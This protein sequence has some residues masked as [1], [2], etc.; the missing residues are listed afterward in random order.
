MPLI[1]QALLTFKTADKKIPKLIVVCTHAKFSAIELCRVLQKSGIKVVFYPVGYS[2]EPENLDK[3]L[4]MGIQV[5][6]REEQLLP[7]IEK[8]DCG[9]ED[10]ARIS[11]VINKYHPILKK[12][13]FTVEQTSGGIR[14]F[15]EHPPAYPV[16][17]VAMSPVKLDIEN[18]RAT[19]EG[20]IQYFSETTGKTLGGKQVLVIG[21]GS[22]GEGLARFARILGANVTVYDQFAT[23]RMFAKHRGYAV[24]EQEEFDHILPRQDVIFMATNAYAGN[25]L[26]IEQ[27]LLMK[28]GAIVC[29]AGSGTGEVGPELHTAGNYS[30]H[31]AD[32]HIR[33]ENGHLV[34]RLKKGDLEK[35]VTILA[36]AFPINLHLGKGTSHDAIEVVMSLML[37]AALKGPEGT[38]AGLQPLGLDIQEHVASVELRSNKRHGTFEPRYV[39]TKQLDLKERPYGGVFPFHNDLS[40]IAN[41]SVARAWFK[42]GSKTRGHYHRRSQEAYYAEKGGANIILWHKDSPEQKTTHTVEPGDYL[43]VPENY[44]HDV[45]V[46]SKDDFECLI[47]ATPPFHPWDQFFNKEAEA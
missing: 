41:H 15:E 7:F 2:R 8:A 11:K 18:R 44:F 23:K 30:M 14:Y 9:L 17:N 4:A 36:R 33:E 39:K 20:V 19:P 32:V 1:D 6:E 25:A 34:V 5:I 16:I 37:L 29:N 40:H 46:T 26:S 28:D 13:F 21:F 35:G 31:D 24:V 22:I 47:I 10:G 3:L 43:L 12:G 42:A 38:A 27:F 45:L